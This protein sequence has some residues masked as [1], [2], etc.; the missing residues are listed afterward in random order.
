[1]ILISDK[2][3]REAYQNNL[4]A[5]PVEKRSHP[6]W[7]N[8]PQWGASTRPVVGVSWYES[9]AYCRWLGE[10]LAASGG[11][12]AEKVELNKADRAFWQGLADGRLQVKLP[13]EAQ[14]EKA[15]RGA[16]GRRYPWG[17]DISPENAN[18]DETGLKQTSPVGM[19]PKG[20]SPEGLLDL[21]GNTWEWT[22]SRWGKDPYKLEYKYPYKPN[23]GREDL[24][25][26][27]LR[28]LRGG[29]WPDDSWFARCAFR[30]R[31]FPV[32]FDDF[33]G[34]RVVVSLA[35]SD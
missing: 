8:H 28:V 14:W 17:G 25:G 5:R 12:W 3:L 21:A 11:Q 30:G 7:W 29:S 23:D 31:Y 4:D 33:I 32:L 35:I 9:L 1:M 6:Y 15:A 16:D 13:S 24:S 10:Q 26:S 19:F 22:S 18:Y 34:F 2:D 20:R 27:H